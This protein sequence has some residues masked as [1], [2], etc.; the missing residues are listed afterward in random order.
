MSKKN[1]KRS[2]VKPVQQAKKPVA[3]QKKRKGNP[4]KVLF[5]TLAV[6]AV[7]A[8]VCVG[9]WFIYDAFFA[10]C[11]HEKVVDKAVAATCEETGLTE[12]AHCAK[13]GVTLIKQDVVEA[14]GHDYGAWTE[15]KAA[16]CEEDGEETRVCAHDETHVETQAIEALGHN[17]TYESY[18]FYSCMNGDW[19]CGYLTLNYSLNEIDRTGVVM[20]KG[21]VPVTDIIIPDN[22]M[23][24]STMI[25]YKITSINQMAFLMSDITSVQIG[26]NVTSIGDSAFGACH[27]LE[28]VVIPDN[29][30][31]LG[32]SVFSNCTG[33]KSVTIG[34]GITTLPESAF[35][36]CTS[37][38]SIVIPETV[39][40][41]GGNVFNACTNLTDIYLEATEVPSGWASNW[42]WGQGA[43]VH[44][45]GTWEYD[46][47]GEPS[48]IAEDEVEATAYVLQKQ[49]EKVYREEEYDPITGALHLP[50]IPF[51]I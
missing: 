46:E 7:V 12:G 16:T 13:C 49:A 38:T 8:A 41:M 50:I 34:S 51:D 48:P 25:S 40:A 33:L 1:R 43:T 20:G 47:N 42:A 31:S 9:G 36:G 14:L 32:A 22:F 10:E 3:K 27:G 11:K 28:S 37:L 45:G 6:V 35:E 39:T 2:N 24:T 44:L 23:K 5:I 21:A 15:T 19:H 29:V 26:A 18:G 17:Y 30:T 4:L